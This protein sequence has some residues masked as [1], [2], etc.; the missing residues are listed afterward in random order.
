MILI[1]LILLPFR[2]AEIG[3]EYI[4]IQSKANPFEDDP[5]EIRVKVTDTKEGWV[6]Y[7]HIPER[8]IFQKDH[9]RKNE[10]LM[11]FKRVLK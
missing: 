8:I 5:K 4:L 6:A 7:E 2:K 11:V 10:F 9:M 1:D 3:A